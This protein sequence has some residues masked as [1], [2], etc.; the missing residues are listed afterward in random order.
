LD[1]RSF[2]ATDNQ[3]LGRHLSFAA[4]E[5]LSFALKWILVIHQKNFLF[6]K[7]IDSVDYESSGSSL[8][9]PRFCQGRYLTTL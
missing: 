2:T 8:G 6:P 1:L 3:L 9:Q 5:R 7:F 4:D